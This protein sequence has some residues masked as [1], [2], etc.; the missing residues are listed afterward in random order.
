MHLT[1]IAKDQHGTRYLITKN[2]WA[3]NSNKTGGY[4]NISEAYAR[5]NT[6][7]IMVHKDALPENIRKKL[8]P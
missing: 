8:Q 4:L 6:I 2:S 5:L 1:G 7:A 3:S